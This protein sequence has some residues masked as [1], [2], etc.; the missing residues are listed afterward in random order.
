M[1]Q[2][3]SAY[4]EIPM[5]LWCEVHQYQQSEQKIQTCYQKYFLFFYHNYVVKLMDM[6]EGN[7]LIACRSTMIYPYEYSCIHRHMYIY[8]YIW[9]ESSDFGI[10]CVFTFYFAS[11]HKNIQQQSYRSC[12]NRPLCATNIPINIVIIWLLLLFMYYIYSIVIILSMKIVMFLRVRVC[13]L[14][15]RCNDICFL[16]IFLIR[17]GKFTQT[18]A[19]FANIL[20]GT[21]DRNPNKFVWYCSP[22]LCFA[23][24]IT[25]GIIWC[26]ATV[27]YHHYNDYFY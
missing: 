6:F 18:Y 16:I 25:I 7:T 8:T 3:H 12:T 4:K 23:M 13:V 15:I 2:P 27:H 10:H 11:I 5:A 1:V 20:L 17:H 9:F 24:K 19:S 14:K 26:F 22:M 21:T